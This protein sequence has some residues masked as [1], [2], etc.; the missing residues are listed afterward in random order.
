MNFLASM[1]RRFAVV[2]CATLLAIASLVFFV[3]PATAATYE[4]K[5]GADNGMLAFVPNNLTVKTGDTVKFVN[6]KLPPHNIVFEGHAELSKK[7]LMFS[8]GESYEVT[9]QDSGKY[10]FYCEPHRG[11]GMVGT[12]TVE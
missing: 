1:S 3:S 11:A 9:F 5:M 8:P 6:N 4:V 12:V 7:Q 2:L 10:S